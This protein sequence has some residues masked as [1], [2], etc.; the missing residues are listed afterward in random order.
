MVLVAQEL[1]GE[2]LPTVTFHGD[3]AKHFCSKGPPAP[4]PQP[5]PHIPFHVLE[6]APFPPQLLAWRVPAGQ[7]WG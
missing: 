6:Q 1:R 3:F 4:A 7:A 5:M 2:T